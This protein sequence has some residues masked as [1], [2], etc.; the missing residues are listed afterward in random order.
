MLAGTGTVTKRE[1]VKVTDRRT[2][3][4][5]AHCMRKL[6]DVHYPQA[7]RIRMV[8]DNLSTHSAAAQRLCVQWMFNADRA[9]KKMGRLYPTRTPATALPL[10]A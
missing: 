6:S 7:E 10:A 4:D 1:R 9:R 8:L 3:Q 5:F 2:A